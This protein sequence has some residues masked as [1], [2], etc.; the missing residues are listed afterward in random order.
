MKTFKPHG[1]HLILGQWVA[2]KNT[3][4]SLPAT[5]ASSEFF[6]AGADEINASVQAAEDAFW[7]YGYV[8]CEKRAAFLNTIADE[9]EARATII[10]QIGCAETG[11]PEARL[12]GERGRTTG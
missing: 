11:L 2:S 10:T 12:N 7:S 5:G 6:V 9:I 4:I 1:Q 8:S 3:F